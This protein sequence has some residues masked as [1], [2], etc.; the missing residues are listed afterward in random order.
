MV[1]VFRVPSVRSIHEIDDDVHEFFRWAE[2]PSFDRWYYTYDPKTDK[3]GIKIYTYGGKY[4]GYSV[5]DGGCICYSEHTK[6]MF[7]VR[8]DYQ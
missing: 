7:L 8:R 4:N 2:D 5:Y 3:I 1:R 6:S